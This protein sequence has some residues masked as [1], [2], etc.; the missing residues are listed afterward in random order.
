MNGRSDRREKE[1]ESERG[2]ILSEKLK[3][4]G[5]WWEKCIKEWKVISPVPLAAAEK[6]VYTLAYTH[7]HTRLNLFI[8]YNLEWYCKLTRTCVCVCMES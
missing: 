7:T 6:I 8:L 1:W 4:L 3:H 5:Y 2:P